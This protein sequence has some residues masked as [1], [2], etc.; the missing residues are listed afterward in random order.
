MQSHS[1][2]PQLTHEL[3]E[4]LQAAKELAEAGEYDRA[5]PLIYEALELD[6]NCAPALHLRG[7]V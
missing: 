2:A 6:P 3:M 5:M 4:R 1:E 7:Y